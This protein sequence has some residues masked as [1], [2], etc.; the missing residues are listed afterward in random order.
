MNWGLVERYKKILYVEKPLLR[1]YNFGEKEVSFALIYPNTY[2]L[3]MSNLGFM[4]IYY[5]INI[6]RDTLCHR[7]FLPFKGD[8]KAFYKT[9]T[10][11]FSLESQV[12]LKDYDIIGFS[13]SFELDYINILKILEISHIPLEKEKRD[14][15]FP[16][17]IAGGPCATFNPEPLTPYIDIFVIGEGEEVIHEVIERY[18]SLRSYG[19]QAVLQGMSSI[20]GVYVPSMYGVEYHDDGRIKNIQPKGNAP[21]K[22]KK[23]WI[24]DLSGIQTS[25]VI[26]SP[27][28]EFK[29]MYLI[30]ISRGCWRNCRYCMAG[31]CYKIP[32]IRELRDIINNAKKA[33]DLGL[34]VG[35]VGAAVSDYPYIDE[36][37]R[38]LIKQ[39]IKFSVS[40]LR[41][42][43]VTPSLVRGLAFS[44]H[45]TITIAPE[46]ASERL[47]KVINKGIG[48]E[49]IFRAVYLA[50]TNNI[51]N[52]KLYFI[53]G[54]PTED[55]EDINQIIIL[56]KRIIDYLN[57]INAVYETIILSINPFIPKPFTPFQWFGMD[58]QDSLNYKMNIIKEGLT[59]Y[60]KVK[61]ILESPKWSIIQGLLSRGDRKLG[62]VLLKVHQYGGNLSAWRKALRELEV[63]F[64]FYLYR[65][66]DFTEILPWSHINLGIDENYLKREAIKAIKE[67][68][69]LP[70]SLEKCS[71]CNI[72]SFK[73]GV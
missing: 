62:R 2:N 36:L 45:K 67:H 3:A 65:K 19:K 37:I 28:S 68:G 15:R 31:Y 54:L 59:R 6:R 35:L 21:A 73:G 60:K 25:S 43:S 4:S 56:T 27:L 63:D 14:E 66:R 32:R 72:C 51:P 41:A 38:E 48:E 16:L 7:G 18:K 50:A 55:L 44:G 71:K 20:P 13:V 52:I 12:P 5:Q 30:E 33:K 61:L 49:D 69:T 29:D 42:D 8:E 46:A 53:I 39:G 40:S 58:R 24:K 9:N 64:D 10:P 70:C 22:V 57:S 26:I 23:R 11:L 1:I 34:R 47:R 17:I